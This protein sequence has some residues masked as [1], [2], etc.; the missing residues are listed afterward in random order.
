MLKFL[1]LIE[2]TRTT[3]SGP[4]CT[5]TSICRDWAEIL[6]VAYCK[7][8]KVQSLLLDNASLYYTY[9]E[10]KTEAAGEWA[11]FL[12]SEVDDR[13]VSGDEVSGGVSFIR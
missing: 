2:S 13:K 5:D 11:K 3:S 4:T 12:Y 7:A 6:D 10:I 8:Q 9:T 1:A